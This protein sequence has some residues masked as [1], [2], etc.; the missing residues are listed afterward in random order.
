MIEN[1]S[2]IILYNKEKI[3]LSI[4]SKLL[5]NQDGLNFKEKKTPYKEAQ[6]N[7]QPKQKVSIELQHTSILW[8]QSRG[9]IYIFFF[10]WK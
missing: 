9:N 6:K 3:R 8:V 1:V 7:G 4:S 2:N 10:E 5:Q